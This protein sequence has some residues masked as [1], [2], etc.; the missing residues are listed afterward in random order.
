[1]QTSDKAKLKKPRATTSSLCK[2]NLAR[3]T[4]SSSRAWRKLIRATSP[5][6]TISRMRFRLMKPI[7]A[8]KKMKIWMPTRWL[9]LYHWIYRTT[10]INYIIESLIMTKIK[11]SSRIK[12]RISWRSPT[13]SKTRLWD[14]ATRYLWTSIQLPIWRTINFSMTKPKML[15]ESSRAASNAPSS[16][17]INKQL[18]ETRHRDNNSK[19]CLI[20]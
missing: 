3:T 18:A 4:S 12:Q 13:S 5:M 7:M 19:V 8:C 16:N 2:P 6:A 11:N 20:I 1:M 15:L 9:L 17:L 10:A 14:T